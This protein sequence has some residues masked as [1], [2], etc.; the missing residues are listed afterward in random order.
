MR[1]FRD[2]LIF[3]EASEGSQS[4]QG[5]KQPDPKSPGL[6]SIKSEITLGKDN[7]YEPFI[8]GDGARENLA[9]LVRAFEQGDKVSFGPKTID[10]KTPK[11]PGQSGSGLTQDRKS[12]V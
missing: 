9:I 12:V 8:V 5:S 1:T 11:T 4:G 7:D 10:P 6:N 2:Y 3:K